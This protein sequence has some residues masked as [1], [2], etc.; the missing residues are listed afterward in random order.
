MENYSKTAHVS[1]SCVNLIVQHGHRETRF[2]MLYLDF[3]ISARKFISFV[4]LHSQCHTEYMTFIEAIPAH[5]RKQIKALAGTQHLNIATE[6]EN[7]NVVVKVTRID[8]N[9]KVNKYTNIQKSIHRKKSAKPLTS[10]KNI[11]VAI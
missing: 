3:E 4:E 6:Q 2:W 10:E 1:T 9:R 7:L 11:K 5:W 8:F